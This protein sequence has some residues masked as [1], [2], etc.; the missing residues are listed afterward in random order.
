[1]NEIPLKPDIPADDTGEK[2]FYLKDVVAQDAEGYAIY[3]KLI[4]DMNLDEECLY[5]ANGGYKII[6]VS[7]IDNDFGLN[8]SSFTEKALRNFVTLPSWIPLNK[9]IIRHRKFLSSPKIK[10][11]A[12]IAKEDLSKPKG[13]AL[14][15]DLSFLDKG[16]M[17]EL[18]TSSNIEF[19]YNTGY[20][21]CFTPLIKPI[22]K[23]NELIEEL[24]GIIYPKKEEYDSIIDFLS[25]YAFESRYGLAK[26]TFIMFG[27]NR[28]TGKNLMF[29]TIIGSIYAGQMCP[30]P[31][32]YDQFTG[33]LDKKFVYIDENNEAS[34]DPIHLYN[35]VKRMSG[36]KYNIVNKKRIEAKMISNG[37]FFGI[38]SN[39]KALNIRDAITDPSQNQF[40]VINTLEEKHKP[41]SI[42]NSKIAL[43][44]YTGLPNFIDRCLGNFVFT[45][46][47]DNYEKMKI[48]SKKIG[49]RYGMEVPISDGLVKLVTLSVS[50]SEKSIIQILDNLVSGYRN[51]YHL[52]T[53]LGYHFVEFKGKMNDNA[54]GFLT[55][56]LLRALCSQEK[57]KDTSFYLF[58]DKYNLVKSMKFRRYVYGAKPTGIL[59]DFPVLIRLFEYNSWSGQ[60]EGY[61]TDEESDIDNIFDTALENE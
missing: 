47:F 20:I 10:N 27:T 7:Y 54:N 2:K 12:Y 61:D 46:L 32:N 13:Y 22:D 53:E 24:L 30:L 9:Y 26:P 28:G 48:R 57:V 6:K 5:W 52:T 37:T 3:K 15:G 39:E 18:A 45:K 21:K 8:I 17:I 36:Q 23:N 56:K 25:L 42:F 31:P 11:L 59:I 14:R 34:L 4:F 35:F 16:D 60:D 1:M 49:F 43:L 55:H 33:Y 38:S 41:I 29:E 51:S 58:L 19:D 50:S 44:G 40:L